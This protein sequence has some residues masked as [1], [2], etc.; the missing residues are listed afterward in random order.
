M[1]VTGGCLCGT[2][3]YELAEKPRETGACHCGM[4]RKFS[5]GVYLGMQ[6]AP[7]G[8]QF[9]GEENIG[10]F[11]SSDWAERGFCKSC[12]SSLFYR[13]TMPGPGQGV[14]HIGLGTLDDPDGV[15]LT[16]EIFVD[17]KPDGY[18]FQGETHKMT[19]A[20]VFAMYAPSA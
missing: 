19:E 15:L 13:V 14:L 5:G 10:V 7:G 9:S 8:A 4:C 3:R 18:A 17:R 12:G 16:G 20:E 1:A 2:V 11:Q 6:V